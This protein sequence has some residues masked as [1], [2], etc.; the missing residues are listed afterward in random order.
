[1]WLLIGIALGANVG[2]AFRLVAMLLRH[3]GGMPL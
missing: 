1:M 2:Y 3:C